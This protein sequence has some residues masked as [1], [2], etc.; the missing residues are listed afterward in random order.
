[1]CRA[2]QGWGF[3]CIKR[4]RGNFL[5][6]RALV[7]ACGNGC[8][9]VCLHSTIRPPLAVPPLHVALPFQPAGCPPLTAILPLCLACCYRLN[10]SRAQVHAAPTT[11]HLTR[12]ASAGGW[13][14]LGLT[15]QAAGRFTLPNGLTLLPLHHTTTG[16]PTHQHTDHY[17]HVCTPQLDKISHA[18]PLLA[19]VL[20]STVFAWH[21]HGS[22]ASGTACAMVPYQ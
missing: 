14:I 20:L 4:S 2:W 1:M 12:Q 11:T 22:L 19:R 10:V 15:Q 8:A 3:A 6:V 13:H 21:K 9:C 5:K 7:L 17:R 18:M 16:T